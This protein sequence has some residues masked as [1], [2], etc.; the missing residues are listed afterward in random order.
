MSGNWCQPMRRIVFA[1]FIIARMAAAQ[2]ALPWAGQAMSVPQLATE[3]GVALFYVASYNWVGTHTDYD[4]ARQAADAY[5]VANPQTPT[6]L[7]LGPAQ[8]Q[9]CDAVALPSISLGNGTS[10]TVSIIGYGSNVSNIIKRVGCAPGSATLRVSES[11]NGPVANAL[12]QGF[13]VSANHIDSAACGFYGMVGGTILDVACGNAAPEADHEV[14]FGN[15]D[16]NSMGRA[17][18]LSIMN[19]KAFDNVGSGGGAILTPVWSAGLLAG[20]TVT[21]GG[22]KMYTQ[23]YIRARVVGPGVS[24]CTSLP[25]LVPIV[26][27]L[28]SVTYPSLPTTQYGYVTGVTVTNPGSCSETAQLYILVQDGVSVMYGMKFT[29][30]VM[31]RVWNLESIASSY[32]A[33]GWLRSSVRNSIIGEHPY[34]GQT[35]QILE[36]GSSNEH[37][38]AYFDGPGEYG[39]AIYGKSGSFINSVFAWNSATYP[40]SSGYHLGAAA[41]V[42]QNWAITNS[43]CTNS[44]ANFISVTT[45]QGPLQ[46]TDPA[47]L[48]VSLHDIEDCDGSKSVDWPTIVGSP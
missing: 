45:A 17:H 13:T 39:A 48:G 27:S 15:L 2:G 34:A 24:S 21:G 47:P 22:T 12:F 8:T 38:N 32:Y 3:T 9:T 25:T 11:A 36:Y 16:A 23:Q 10:A 19:L 7:V 26:S 37:I 1:L 41:N 30:L 14:E 31:S 20:V 5:L 42:Y 44:T 6:Y 43:Q 35:I 40:A 28:A 29:N 4:M 33:E 18:N 46:A